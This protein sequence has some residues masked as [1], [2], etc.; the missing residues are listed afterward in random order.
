MVCLAQ[1]DVEKFIDLMELSRLNYKQVIGQAEYNNSDK[2]V[3]D[4]NQSFHPLKLIKK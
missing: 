3:Y 2:R 4:F 1:G